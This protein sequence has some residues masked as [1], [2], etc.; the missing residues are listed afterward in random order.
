MSEADMVVILRSVRH[1]L[2]DARRLVVSTGL[3]SETVTIIK[4]LIDAADLAVMDCI[5]S[6]EVR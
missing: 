6:T 5:K 3:K 2:N 1:R 4:N